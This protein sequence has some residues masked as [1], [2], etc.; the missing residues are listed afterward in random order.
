MQRLCEYGGAEGT[1]AILK[2]HFCIQL[3]FVFMVFLLYCY[4]PGL[5]ELGVQSSPHPLALVVL[6]LTRKI[7]VYSI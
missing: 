7:I 1:Q 3:F 5:N 2:V 6:W 4:V